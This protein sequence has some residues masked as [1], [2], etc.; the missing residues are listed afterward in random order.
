ML[1]VT[2]ALVVAACSEDS[3]TVGP[4][5]AAGGTTSAPGGTGGEA[6]SSGGSSSTTSSSGGGGV[7]GGGGAEA[8]VYQ[9]VDG[10]VAVEAEHFETNDDQ[11]T[12]RAWY[13]TTPSVDPDVTPDPDE[14]HADSA[15]NTAYVEGLPDTRVTDSDPI[16]EGESIFNTVGTGPTLSYRVHFD[17]PGTYYVWV[18][19][20]STG[21]ED[22]GI[23][24]GIDGSWPATGERVQFCSGKNQW[25]WS[26]AQR[27]SGSPPS[28]CGVP[29]TITL[30]VPSV[31]E[32]VVSFSMRE[33]GFEFDKWIM[34][35]DVGYVPSGAGPPEVEYTGG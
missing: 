16:Q 29:N 26:S 6:T 30:D 27:D 32:H 3:D 8:V 11:G 33:D 15:S 21:T 10:L 22:N 34:T 25:T 35:D 2:A 9:E 7:G 19:A 14:P 24:A 28:S 1:A 5:T 18:R 20:Y 4:T 13:L 17:H 23:H 31:G 12:A